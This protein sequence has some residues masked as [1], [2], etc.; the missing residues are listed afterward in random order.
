MNQHWLWIVIGAAC[1]AMGCQKPTS[2]EMSEPLVIDEFSYPWAKESPPSTSFEM[3]WKGNALHFRFDVDDPD[4]VVAST[5]DGESTVDHE[6]RVELFFARDDALAQYYC[7]EIDPL[8]RVHDYAA[9]HYRQFDTRW[10]CD[11][12]LTRGTR[13]PTGY[14][15][16]GS[17]PGATLES[18]LG[19]TVKRGT[20]IKM[21]VFRAE[22]RSAERETPG[23]RADNWISWVKPETTQPDFHVPSAFRE[24]TL[25]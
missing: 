8:G 21:G 12:S 7:V 17:I 25:R 23:A 2:F 18:M 4:V 9:R 11:G 6:D 20:T 22:F 13:T 16:E 15:V 3:Q 5:W 19:R 1:A 14:R 10:R 24:V